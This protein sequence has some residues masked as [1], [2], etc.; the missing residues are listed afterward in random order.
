MKI[1]WAQNKLK[2]E[3]TAHQET[4]KQLDDALKKIRESKEESEKIRKD[5][6]SMIRSV[7]VNYSNFNKH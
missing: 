2:A 1:K 3:V 6:Q 4:R 5:F 7:Q